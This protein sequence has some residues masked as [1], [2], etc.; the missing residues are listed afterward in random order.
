M[1]GREYEAIEHNRIG[2]FE[3]SPNSHALLLVE[4]WNV[5]H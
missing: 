2:Q 3:P 5:Q 1:N 4:I